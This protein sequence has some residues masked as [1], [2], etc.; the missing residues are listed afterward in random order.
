MSEVKTISKPESLKEKRIETIADLFEYGAK[1]WSG[2]TA[3]RKK[4]PWGYQSITYE[5]FN[6]LVSF[7]G[8]GLI[9][10]GLNTGDRV[11]LIA[12]NSPEWPVVYG[13]VIS[14]G[15][16]VVPLDP[17]MN[18]N[19]IRHL[20][21]HSESRFLVTE[22]DIYDSRISQMHLKE[23]GIILIEEGK[24][25][26][27][28]LQLGEIMAK[29]K[30]SINGGESAFFKRKARVSGD[31]TAAIC[32]T[33]GATGSPK[34]VVLLHRNI[35]SNIDSIIN[36]I[37][38]VEDD[39]FLCMLP[40][41]HTFSTTCA[42]LTP[43]AVGASVVFCRSL[44]PDKIIEDI[45]N[46]DISVLIGVPLIFEH[47]LERIGESSGKE[48]LKEKGVLSRLFGKI[49]SAVSRLIGKDKISRAAPRAFGSIRICIS[50]A[51]P[52]RPDVEE[53]LI[54]SGLNLL[55]G[56][57]L[58]EAAPVVS[59]NPPDKVRPGT[60]GPA[61]AGVEVTIHSPDGEGNGEIVVN[62][63]NVMKEYFKNP[64]ETSRVLRSGLLYTGDL[65]R[66]DE[67]GYIT[68]KGRKKS[69]IVTAGGKNIFPSELETM[70]NRSRYILESAIT[71]IED[72]RG[73]PRAGAII[74]PDYDALDY[75]KDI[76]KPI[77]DTGIREIMAGI[78]EEANRELPDYGKIAD[79]RI[80]DGELPRTT[81]N[82]L[83]RHM[84]SWIRE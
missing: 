79:F 14:A 50:G 37:P 18:E 83:K 59:V 69:V 36:T 15:G 66:I 64:E 45:R 52:L 70:L 49:K 61:L 63:P 82:K 42:F 81:T 80:T 5:E 7:L 56:Y 44:R 26:S 33:S 51:A 19:E 78:V 71:P 21:M 54:G 55:Q 17:S 67:D 1:N 73:N 41:Y 23:T 77:S 34:G 8:A 2:N 43:L 74:V 62:G 13:A 22:P 38:L 28:T 6:R 10:E 31:D 27:G 3:F 20:L 11:I 65:G 29:G 46:E 30:T 16:V 25:D 60:V 47:M 9:Q 53:A 75:S 32:Y 57:G 84:V 39:N 58:T 40:L 35:L 4:H 48:D 68:I 12:G 72:R 76:E 24:T